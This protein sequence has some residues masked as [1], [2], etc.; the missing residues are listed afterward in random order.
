MSTLKKVE[1]DPYTGSFTKDGIP[2][3]THRQD[4]YVL[5][6]HKGRQVLAHRAAWELHYGVP[7]PDVLDHINGIRSDNRI[8]NLRAATYR[9]NSQNQR[10]H[11]DSSSGF[12]GV[13]FSKARGKFVAYIRNGKRTR[14]LGGYKTAEEAHEVYCLAA[15]LIFGE[16]ARGA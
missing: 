8:A 15:E 16:F 14:N 2:T 4:G 6:S 1:Y 12:K 9:Q 10:R 5:V 7:A 13:S 11:R 3:G